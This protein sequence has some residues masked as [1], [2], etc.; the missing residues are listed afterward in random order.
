MA[1]TNADIANQALSK[2]G[3]AAIQALDDGSPNAQACELVFAAERDALL[4]SYPW[5]FAKKRK[6]LPLD[7][8]T[9]EFGFAYAYSLPPDFMEIL[10]PTEPDRPYE[11]E[12]GLLLSDEAE[13][14]VRYIA[15]I[16][17][18]NAMTPWFR[19]ALAHKLA[20]EIALKVAKDGVRKKSAL[21]ATYPAAL[22]EAKRADARNSYP[23]R[24][25]AGSWVRSR[26]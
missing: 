18:A 23:K 14:S 5:K 1:S 25:N 16:T 10:P 3:V 7:G 15:R 9:P 4:A 21:E 11:I 22:A 20:I 19:E 13:L 6:E 17:D 26:F 8:S 12:G 2:L 24:R